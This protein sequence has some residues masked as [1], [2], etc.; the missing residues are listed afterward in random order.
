[1][2]QQQQ[3]KQQQTLAADST[4]NSARP[5]PAPLRPATTLTYAHGQVKSQL[6][7]QSVS[8]SESLFRTHALVRPALCTLFRFRFFCH[9]RSTAALLRRQQQQ[10]QGH[11]QQL[12]PLQPD[13]L[14]FLTYCPV[15]PSLSLCVC[16]CF[17]FLSMR[18]VEFITSLRYVICL[19]AC[20]LKCRSACRCLL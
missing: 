4:P 10:Q 2:Q 12:Q 13:Q 18:V 19:C 7:Q 15:S 9:F 14:S 5:P 11:R 20:P 16:V 3:Q 1:M 17:C 8:E 6:Q